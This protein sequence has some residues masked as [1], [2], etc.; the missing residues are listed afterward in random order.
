MYILGISAFYHDSAAC[1]LK[2]GRV[3][4]ASQ[5]ERF[6][7]K[8]HDLSFPVNAI[9]YCLEQGHIIIDQVDYLAFYDKPFRK[10]DRILLDAP[11]T[12]LG[13]LRRNPDA[14][15]VL[16][17]KNF[18]YYKTRQIQFLE[19]LAPLLKINGLL[20]YCVCSM[21]P[22]ENEH[23]IEIFLEKH[24]EFIIL[25]E[26]QDLHEGTLPFVDQRGFFRTKPH[27]DNMDGFFAVR[28]SKIK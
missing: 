12:G 6:T 13:V 17:K 4:A 24:P 3:I 14:K 26:R 28:L 23:V 20:L 22:E 16:S 27:T 15:W 11:C 1:L 5:E 9:R 18:P 19:V 2:D 21:E 10:F 7:R 8:K 25:K